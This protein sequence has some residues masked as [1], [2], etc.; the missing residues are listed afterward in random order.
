MEICFAFNKKINTQSLKCLNKTATIGTKGGNYL[1]SANNNNTKGD[2]TMEF[3]FY[4]NNLSDKPVVIALDEII[5]KYKTHLETI[6]SIDT[7]CW[8]TDALSFLTQFGSFD[9]DVA[10]IEEHFYK[11]YQQAIK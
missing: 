6:E 1:G 4:K 11:A 9:F 3:T 10:Q 8:Q 2:Q 7:I 5:S